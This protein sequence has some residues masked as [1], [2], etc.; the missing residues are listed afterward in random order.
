MSFREI[1]LE[2]GAV[3]KVAPAPFVEARDLY[4]ALL[5]EIKDVS[6]PGQMEIR[7]AVTRLLCVGFSSKKIEA[8]VWK[9]M[10][11]CLYQESKITVD[12]FEPASARGDYILVVTEVVLENVTPFGK[13]LYAQ[14]RRITEM[15]TAMG[16]AE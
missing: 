4:Q 2:S 11:R 1:K 5:S 6:A 9:C 13:S 15:T 16:A 3:L 12:S 8:A 10:E 7:E 14:L